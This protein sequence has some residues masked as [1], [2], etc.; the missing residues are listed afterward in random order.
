MQIKAI[1]L[2][3]ALIFLQTC[4]FSPVYKNEGSLGEFIGGISFADPRNNI[5]FSFLRNI[6]AKLPQKNTPT[7][8]MSY[9]ISVAESGLVTDRNFLT[10]KVIF[11]LVNISNN[12][13]ILIGSEQSSASF[14]T[15]S[16]F[17]DVIAATTSREDALERLSE[18]LA[19]RVYYFVVASV[20]HLTQDPH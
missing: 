8:K 19:Q 20:P 4:G 11:S 18:M 17:S 2:C 7:M 15:S 10:G 5:E 16:R 6:E 1:L 3:G 13:V 12:S 9:S 14:Q